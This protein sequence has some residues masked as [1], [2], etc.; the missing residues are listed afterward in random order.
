MKPFA[1]GSNSLIAEKYA[2]V[3]IAVFQIETAQQV[4]VRLDPV[5][6]IDVDDFRKLSQLLSSS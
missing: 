4:A 6:V 2:N 1:A 3:G 5:R